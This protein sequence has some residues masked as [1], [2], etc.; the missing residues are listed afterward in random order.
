VSNVDDFDYV[1][2]FERSV[3]NF[4]LVSFEQFSHVRQEWPSSL[5][6]ADFA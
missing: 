2:G 5:L 1:F 4:E 6:R 3:E